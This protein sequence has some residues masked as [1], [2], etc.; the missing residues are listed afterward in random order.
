MV[1]NRSPSRSRP[2]SSSNTL[3]TRAS[4]ATPLRA[5]FCAYAGHRILRDVDG[6]RLVARAAEHQ[7][8]AAVVAEAVEQPA[9]RVGG[10]R[11]A[12]F[13]LVEKQTG[14]L[15]APEIDV[16]LDAG[17]RHRHGLRHVAGQDL[18]PLLEPFEHSRPRIVARENPAR[19][20]QLGEHRR[21]RRQQPI[22]PLRQRLNDQVVA[23]AVDNQRRQEVRFAV[24]QP[25]RARVDRERLA[26]RDR[27]FETPADQR[28]VGRRVAVRQH[29]ERDLRAVAVERGPERA[30][31]RTAD[32]H[33]VTRPA[34][35]FATSAR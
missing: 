28:E 14:L 31:S 27:R 15:S 6:D 13:P 32:L 5:A 19:L 10:G 26:K 1:S 12:V 24:H 3:P 17:F 11:R 33:D 8:E 2:R 25:I 16:V 4:T 9:A 20:Q 29:A 34:R 30:S 21:Q 18:D 35:T 23:V 22:H 7:R